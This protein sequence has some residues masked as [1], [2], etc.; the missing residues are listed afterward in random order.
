MR[1]SLCVWRDYRMIRIKKALARI[2]IASINIFFPKIKENREL[3][4][5]NRALLEKNRVLSNQVEWFKQHA[6]ITSLK[7][8]VGFVRK[9]QVRQIEFLNSFMNEISELD[10]HPFILAGT[11]IGHVRHNGFVP[12]DNDIDIGLIREEYDKLISF[13]KEK[14]CID[15][16]NGRWSEYNAHVHL[17]RMN[18]LVKMHPDTFVLDIWVDQL[19]V[20]K[21][22]SV[23]DRLALDIFSFD[24]YVDNYRIEDH[25]AYLSELEKKRREIDFVADIVDYLEKER[26]SNPNI[27]NKETEH[28]FPGIDS[29]QGYYRKNQ[30]NKWI[31]T[32]SVFPLKPCTFEGINIWTA[33]NENDFL[34][35][36]Y[37]DYM[38]YPKDVGCMAHEW[39]VEEYLGK[40]FP[41][42]EF[43]LI[44]AFEIYH[45]LPIYEYF[46]ER[47]IFARFVAEPPEINTSGNWF[48]YD[49]AIRILNNNSVRYSKVC[50]PNASFAFTTQE[51]N[52]LCKYYGKKVHVAYGYGF[53]NYCF[54]ESSRTLN[55]F[56]Y[57]LVHGPETMGKISKLNNCPITY[58]MGYPK[59]MWNVS[60][61]YGETES[62]IDEVK[63]ANKKNKPILCYFPTWDDGS[64]ITWYEHEMV[65]IKKDFF[66]IT[67]LH[68]C[69]SR[70]ESEQEKRNIAYRISDLVCYGNV[71]LEEI[72]KI[73][74]IAICDAMSGAAT[75]VPLVNKRIDLLLLFSP[76]KEKND[77]K[78]IIN[79][80][81]Y[82]IKS[83][84]ELDAGIAAVFGHDPYKEKRIEL[85]DRIFANTDRTCLDG[86]V[87]EI[88][89]KNNTIRR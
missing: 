79:Q 59:H 33:N 57:K 65:K 2:K 4:E 47:G 82:L 19:Q 3:L 37:P 88:I 31:N 1:F 13:F 52:L 38:H 14:Y 39:Y 62:I 15:V 71:N 75:E 76:Q 44:D 60:I 43:Y 17:D 26:K 42:V 41:S 68:H 9:E 81:S 40:E 54:C 27:S 56:D 25:L 77:Y 69:T 46:V 63:A 5:K 89:E 51:A 70:L 32:S 67:K 86:L 58:I 50:N 23:L 24:Y 83:P 64:S 72:A 18:E 7:P 66:V 21:G 36:Q 78:I 49:E 12:W 53:G 16:Y 22:T 35:Y 34:E 8:A 87:S 74:S 61:E 73:S 6:P 29:V 11:L 30:T 80:F 45:F 55:G 85:L 84:K 48:D 28:I 20:M 10:L